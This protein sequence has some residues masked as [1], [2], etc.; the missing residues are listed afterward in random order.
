MMDESLHLTPVDVRR[1]DFGQKFRGCDP[2][3]VENFRNRVAE[4]LERLTRVNQELESKAKG[5]HEQ[6]RAFRERDK[7]LNEALVSAQQLR[8]EIRDQADRE[9]QVLLRESKVEA[10][11]AVDEARSEARNTLESARGDA[12][13]MLEETQ[14]RVRTLQAEVQQLEK[15]RRAFTMQLRSMIERQLNELGAM[16]SATP[17]VI[18]PTSAAMLAEVP[19]AS[20]P[21]PSRTM[22]APLPPVAPVGGHPAQSAPLATPAPAAPPMV[23]TARPT[24]ASAIPHLPIPDLGLAA[25]EPHPEGRNL[26]TPAWLESFSPGVNGE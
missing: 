12:R 20:S 21:P 17:P 26:K 2:V 13:K 24:P 4:E 1:W 8:T 16:E 9:G 25:E 19:Q 23:S 6:L 15:S 5:F 11:R 3:Q 7:A 14:S 22:A 10:E 18:P